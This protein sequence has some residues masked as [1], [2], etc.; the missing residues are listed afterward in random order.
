MDKS[1]FLKFYAS[2][3]NVS[4]YHEGNA[5][6]FSPMNVDVNNNNRPSL[7]TFQRKLLFS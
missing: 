3:V 5:P 6:N 1:F 4:C 2:G 7:Q